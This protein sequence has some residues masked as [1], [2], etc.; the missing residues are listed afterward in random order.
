MVAGLG[1]VEQGERLGGLAAGDQQRAD[2]ALERG[3]ALLDR[4][5]RRVHDPGVDVAELL[6]RE[7][8]RGVV[9]VV[10]GVGGG[11]VDRQ[12][13]GVGGARPGVWP[14]WI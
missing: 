2:A 8:V 4:G 1:E 6:E 9:G 5:L 11:L 14:A 13:P 7:Q 10:E 3:D 12:G